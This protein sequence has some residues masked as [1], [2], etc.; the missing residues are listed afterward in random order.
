MTLRVNDR[1]PAITVTTSAGPVDVRDLWTR[2]PLVVAF[3]RMWCPFCQQAALELS[4]L[5]PYLAGVGGQAVIVYREGLDD[6]ASACAERHTQA[7]C[8][9]DADRA[10]ERAVDLGQFGL[11]HYAAFNPARLVRARRAGARAHLPGSNVLQGRATFVIDTGGRV[12]Y[13]HRATTAADI[14]PVRDLRE[15][16]DRAAMP[17]R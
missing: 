2:G 14:P 13:V 3:H 5:A 16:I 1:F 6:V 8:V 15:A 12:V 10:L 17:V 11:A 4:S 7:L 9:S